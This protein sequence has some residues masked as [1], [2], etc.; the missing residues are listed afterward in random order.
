MKNQG[1]SRDAADPKFNTKIQRYK[2]TKKNLRYSAQS[3]DEKLDL[4]R[5][6]NFAFY[7][8]G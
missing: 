3:A 2:G 8:S 4:L 6:V 1:L 5:L 7:S